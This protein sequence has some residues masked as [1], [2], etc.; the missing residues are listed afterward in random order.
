MF[1]LN[2][3]AYVSLYILGM[4]EQYC[5]IICKFMKSATLEM[6][7]KFQVAETDHKEQYMFLCI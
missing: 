6:L 4:H 7:S 3:V 5:K 1:A 2:F